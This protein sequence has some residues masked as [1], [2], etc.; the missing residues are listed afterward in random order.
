MK[1]LRRSV[2]A[3]PGSDAAMLRKAAESRAD[4]VL[5]DLED[6][7]APAAKVDARS[8]VVEALRSISWGLKVV[9]VRIN[10]VR[11]R[12][13]YR[14]LVEV[15][16]AAGDRLD[17]VMVPKVEGPEDLLFV[18]R[19]LD[20]IEAHAGLARRLG[21][22][23][24]IESAAGCTRVEEIA[25]ATDRL[26][27]IVFGPGDYAAD[28]GM[29]VLSIGQE[30][31]GYPGHLWHYAMA[32][33]VNA[34]RAAGLQ[35]IDGPWGALEDLDGLRAS[36][37]LARALGFEGKWAVHPSQ[38]DPINEMF[39]PT[40]AEVASARRIVDAYRQAAGGESAQGVRGAL[41]HEG[42]LIDAASVRM[43]QQVLRRAEQIAARG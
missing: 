14:D 42:E 43:A 8:T 31:S 19:L 39:A 24:Q 29:P 3:T 35:A 26:R 20:G 33:I 18:A 40:S 28:L 23:A 15:V 17:D 16:E 2:L 4:E 12:W 13:A 5:L 6:A 11:T 10:D 34:A 9:V 41:R 7:V 30:V 38:I 37:R 36:A 27:T 21:L 1:T 25:L 32:R 22:E